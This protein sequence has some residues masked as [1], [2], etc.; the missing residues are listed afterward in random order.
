MQL[1]DLG[2][3][4]WLLATA[5]D[6][7]PS[8]SHFVTN[9]LLDFPVIALST[10]SKLRPHALQSLS[11][12]KNHKE[13]YEQVHLPLGSHKELLTSTESATYQYML[14]SVKIHFLTKSLYVAWD[15]E[16]NIP[17]VGERRL[18]LAVLV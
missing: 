6:N 14:Q 7:S 1:A 17:L 18:Y 5:T 15:I 10:Y 2:A 4:A 3:A 13:V 9:R 11:L 8:A 12:R 16:V